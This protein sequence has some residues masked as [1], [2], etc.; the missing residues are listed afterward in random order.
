VSFLELAYAQG[1]LDAMNLEKRAWPA[2]T[3]PVVQNSG[4]LTGKKTQL[5]EGVPQS[6]AT[7]QT[8]S[9][10]WNL[11]EQAKTRLEPK[12]KLSMEICTTCRKAKHYGPCSAPRAI[13]EKTAALETSLGAAAAA[14]VKEAV[15]REQEARIRRALLRTDPATLA[16]KIQENPDLWRS[17]VGAFVPPTQELFSEIFP[18]AAMLSQQAGVRQNRQAVFSPGESPRDLR[19]NDTY[20]E[21]HVWMK[22]LL[23]EG[24]SL[25]QIK[26]HAHPATLHYNPVPTP[27]ET[28]DKILTSGRH[29]E[30]DVV[31]V[32]FTDDPEAAVKQPGFN[33]ERIAWRGGTAAPN[34]DPPSRGA[35]IA[36]RDP[37][38]FSGLP[39]VSAGYASHGTLNA[40][41]LEGIPSGAQG[42]WT[43]HIATDP[44]D[45]SPHERRVV[46]AGGG[47]RSGRSA[48]GESPF[49][50][51]VIDAPYIP[52]PVTTYKPLSTPGKFQRVRGPNLLAGEL[53]PLAEA[54]A[55]EQAAPA[56][57]AAVEDIAR[58]GGALPKLRAAG[59]AAGQ[60]LGRAGS[61]TGRS[62]G[63]A[64]SALSSLFK[65]GDF[66]P[67]LSAA[68]SEAGL[69]SPATSAGYHSATSADTSLAR[70]RDSQ[71]AD[72][73]AGTAF[74]D[75]YRH[76]GITS[77]TDE[78]GR[79]YGGLWKTSK[80]MISS[81]RGLASTKLS[82]WQLWGTGG[83]SQWEDR[84][85][86]QTPNPYEERLT[87]KSPPVG[88]GDEG[89]QRIRRTFDQIDGAV[90]TANI[91]NVS[92]DPG[93]AVGL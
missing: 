64:G 12:R 93:P 52:D 22:K 27:H 17:A 47:R 67:G 50:E 16:S 21:G 70:A 58:A 2:P 42:P 20:D 13:P 36:G 18:G 76:L 84:G 7:P 90:D 9:Q 44:R 33:P 80:F 26:Q 6:P 77:Q 29:R 79:Q 51:K 8:V 59:Q 91:E 75:L 5:P 34:S 40:Y 81:A 48:V 11:Q 41:P 28:I 23:E 72:V 66:N 25:E 24:R 55:V 57:T 30:S 74:A 38:W 49:Y 19:P 88:W 32:P 46:A 4:L 89:E 39:S 60:A 15:G 53:P 1:Q 85:P 78:P 56:A 65:R 61:A 35:S 62:L 73:Q 86:G 45:L 87:I 83:H 37:R 54:R 43:R 10:T 68:S 69:D 3:S 82:G 14:L 92:P 71:P 31:S 63:R